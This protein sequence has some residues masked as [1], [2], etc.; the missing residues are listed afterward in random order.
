MENGMSRTTVMTSSIELTAHTISCVA[1]TAVGVIA[2]CQT[3]ICAEAVAGI[4]AVIAAT[5]LALLKVLQTD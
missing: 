2:G 4:V 1:G 5:T 3:S